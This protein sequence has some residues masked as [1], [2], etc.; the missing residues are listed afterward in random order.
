MKKITYYLADDGTK[1]DNR[2][3]CFDYEQEQKRKRTQ[4][5]Q[6]EMCRLDDLLW[7]VFYPN[8]TSSNANERKLYTAYIWLTS[9]IEH[10]LLDPQFSREESEKKILD[11]IKQSEYGEE[12]LAKHISMQAIRE[13]V[14]LRSDFATALRNVKHGSDLSSDLSYSLSKLDLKQL[15]TLHKAKK[16]RRKIEDLLTDCN[17]HSDCS[18]FINGNYE[19]YMI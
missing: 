1:F 19:E 16:F 13:N 15:A 14:N 5:I 11:T 6:E 4:A 7:S 9:D 17:F 3:S 8:D 12:I 18:Q 10:I 2:D